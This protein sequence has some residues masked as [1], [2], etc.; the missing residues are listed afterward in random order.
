M[1]KLQAVL[2]KPTSLLITLLAQSACQTPAPYTEV[3]LE[4]PQPARVLLDQ[5]PWK[6]GD[7]DAETLFFLEDG[8]PQHSTTVTNN[9]VTDRWWTGLKIYGYTTWGTNPP[10]D[11][12]PLSDE[13]WEEL[14]DEQLNM[15]L[16]SH[17]G[18]AGGNACRSPD[19]LP[20]IKNGTVLMRP[21]ETR[22]Y[23]DSHPNYPDSPK[24]ENVTSWSLTGQSSM[25]SDK[26]LDEWP[27]FQIKFEFSWDEE[28]GCHVAVKR[29]DL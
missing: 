29:S 10:S 15:R 9:N 22:S 14:S 7:L 25:P 16:E 26:A 8:I 18:G 28:D 2:L 6:L 13:E 19:A 17:W 5:K 11:S 3:A 23:Q 24:R 27:P 1:K 4:E 12:R 20:E 21:G